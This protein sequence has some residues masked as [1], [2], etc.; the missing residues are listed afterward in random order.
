MSCPRR[1]GQPDPEQSQT[2]TLHTDSS[3]MGLLI[4]KLFERFHGK[5]Q[6]IIMVGLD[7]AGKTTILYKLKL[8]DVVSTIPTIGF[9][10]ETVQYKNTTFTMWDIGGQDKIRPLRP[11]CGETAGV[12]PAAAA[13]AAA[14]PVLSPDPQTVIPISVCLFSVGLRLVPT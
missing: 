3:S 13:A 6:R 9:N 12:G 11:A 2:H 14:A 10:V 7:A 1:F 5:E 8:G 4:S